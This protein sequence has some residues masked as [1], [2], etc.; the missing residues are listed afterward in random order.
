[1]G[2]G[3]IAS[4]IWSGPFIKRKAPPRRLKALLLAPDLCSQFAEC[5][6]NPEINVIWPQVFSKSLKGAML[7]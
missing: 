7:K 2:W 3:P 6:S 5:N 4:R 1:L